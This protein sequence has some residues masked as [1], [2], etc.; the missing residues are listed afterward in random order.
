MR[1]ASHSL[2]SLVRPSFASAALLSLGFAVAGTTAHGQ[3]GLHGAI[4][5]GGVTAPRYMGAEDYRTRPFP[6]IQLQ[7]GERAF[8]GV[9]PSGLGFGIGAHLH[10]GE[11]VGLQ[12]ALSQANARKERYGDALAGMGD[13]TA[14]ATAGVGMSI[15][16]GVVTLSASAAT[17]L[18]REV[19]S[20]GDVSIA[21]SHAIGNR[22]TSGVSTGATLADRRNMQFD[23]GVSEEEAAR[24][25]ALID[26]GD[27]RLRAGDGAAYSPSAGLKQMSASASLGYAVTERTRLMVFAQGT[28]LS[29]EAARSSLVR[30]RD[31]VS[32]G[33]ALVYGF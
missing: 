15:R 24:R 1:T 3:A 13:Q 17:G 9:L 18:D 25:Q 19:G 4:G 33:M 26:A 21:T 14:S 8:A 11:A 5:V 16:Q 31:A 22:W 27:T 23:F 2:D 20:M 30:D 12:V 29:N 32:G 6:Y 10:R 28:R 7:Y